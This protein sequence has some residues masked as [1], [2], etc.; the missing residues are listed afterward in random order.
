MDIYILVS[1]IFYILSIILHLLYFAIGDFPVECERKAWHC[2]LQLILSV[3][4]AIWAY[5][6]LYHG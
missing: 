4:F 2:T 3:G 5:S 6:L 1:L